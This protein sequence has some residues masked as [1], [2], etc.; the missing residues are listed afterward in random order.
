[1]LVIAVTPA[2][3]GYLP[4]LALFAT[5]KGPSKVSS[6]DQRPQDP[7]DGVKRATPDGRGVPV[8]GQEQARASASGIR[9]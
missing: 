8:H 4:L 9:R 2:G 6:E 1:V 3:F 7:E 5:S